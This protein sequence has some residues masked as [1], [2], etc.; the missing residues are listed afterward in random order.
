M[1]TNS[2]I[3]SR[4]PTMVSFVAIDS[5]TPSEPSGYMDNEVRHGVVSDRG[6]S[7]LGQR[8]VDQH[9]DRR[10]AGVNVTGNPTVFGFDSS[11]GITMTFNGVVSA[12][13]RL[14][15]LLSDWC[16][17]RADA[18]RAFSRDIIPPV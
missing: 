12:A 11:H 15:M 6:N 18:K 9:R 2:Q 3:E 17:N 8:H 7:F 4:A 16:P 14:S 13:V 10:I 5:G 1:S